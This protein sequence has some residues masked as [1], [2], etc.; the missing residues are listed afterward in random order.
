MLV[1]QVFFKTRK[2]VWLNFLIDRLAYRILN[3]LKQT[4]VEF[5][6]LIRITTSKVTKGG[7]KQEGGAATQLRIIFTHM[8]QVRIFFLIAS[9]L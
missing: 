5:P 4:K 7:C 8:T 1:A 6:E 2:N 9:V 3:L